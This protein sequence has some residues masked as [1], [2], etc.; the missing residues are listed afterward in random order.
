MDF[1]IPANEQNGVMETFWTMLRECETKADCDDDRV[2]V[3][4]VEAWYKQW[5]RVT[6]DNKQPV[7][8]TRKQARQA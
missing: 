6:G 2:L 5:N 3:H 4:W 7:W 1:K 8:V